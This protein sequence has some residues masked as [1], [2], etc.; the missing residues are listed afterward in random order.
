MLGDIGEII[1]FVQAVTG[2]DTTSAIFKK[3]KLNALKLV[4]KDRTLMEEMN[5]FTKQGAIKAEITV[6]GD[7][8]NSLIW[9]IN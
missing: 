5:V 2:C 3:G 6:A 7:V 1:L 4:Q 8:F 9:W